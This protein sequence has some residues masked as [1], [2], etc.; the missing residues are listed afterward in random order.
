MVD[1]TKME[2]VV[3]EDML[4][5]NLLRSIIKRD[6]LLEHQ[7][8]CG[9]GIFELKSLNFIL[10]Y[11][12]EGIFEYLFM[13]WLQTSASQ[14]DPKFKTVRQRVGKNNSIDYKNILLL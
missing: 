10:S 1:V 12:L 5:A 13:F 6:F 2:N 11:P 4:E 8:L 9:K 7:Q 14:V 3:A